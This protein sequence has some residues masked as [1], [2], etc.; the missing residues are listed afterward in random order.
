MHFA[1]YAYV[2]ESMSDPGAYYRNNVM[3]TMSLLEVM[4]RH[5]VARIVFSSTCAIY[6]HPEAVP[7]TEDH[8]Q[9]PANPY[10]AS[11]AMVERILA[12]YGAAYGISS[13]SL[14]YF[15]AAGA[16]PD[17]DIGEA[18]S[19]ETHAI[20]LILM[21]ARG[22]IPQFDIYGTD[23]PTRDGTAIRDY[24]HVSDLADGHVRALDYLLGGGESQAINL[25]TG[26]GTSVLSLLKIAERLTGRAV[27]YRQMPRRPGD[28][29]RLVADAAKAQAVLGWRP[30]FTKV[31]DIVETALEYFEANFV[32]EAVQLDLGRL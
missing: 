25:G 16:D 17:G 24:I 4:R 1:A 9:R 8:P 27:P 12:D 13:V 26:T 6:G 23:Y 32:R 10:G 22:D 28:P 29:V 18:H 14:R 7:L 15:N 21:A 20:P 2:G 11:K 19:P 5:G 30:T 31:E 3:G